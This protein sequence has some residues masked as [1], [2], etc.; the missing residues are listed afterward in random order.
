MAYQLAQKTRIKLDE[1]IRA[2]DQDRL[3]AGNPPDII[4]A[5]REAS[6]QEC[7]S[8]EK[9]LTDAIEDHPLG[10]WLTG[11][12]G[13]STI[14]AAKILSRI[15]WK[16]AN[17]FPKLRRF[18][19]H[20]PI[21]GKAERRTKGQTNAYCSELRKDLFVLASRGFIMQRS[22]PYRSIY[23]EQKARLAERQCDDHSKYDKECSRCRM[24]N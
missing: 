23:D 18:A 24:L 11:I 17:T 2:A 8:M 13:V 14:T 15:N 16:R 10:P 22:E 7:K 20:A 3:N 19:G 4:L 1:I 5:Y 21:D 6:I 12:R 9:L